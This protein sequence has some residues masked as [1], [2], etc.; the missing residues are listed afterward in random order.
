MKNKVLVS[1]P[2]SLEKANP[3]DVGYDLRYVGEGTFSVEFGDKIIVPT[4][5]KIKIED[6]EP[7]SNEMVWDIQLRGRSSMAAAGFVTHVGTIDQTYHSE[8]KVVLWYFGKTKYHINPGDKIAQLVFSKAYN[9]KVYP[10]E[11]IKEN[12]GG[13]GSS[14]K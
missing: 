6:N 3:T 8:I 4:G 14:G 10:I 13:F 1:A 12:R 9:L 7:I 2:Y 5:C 11:D